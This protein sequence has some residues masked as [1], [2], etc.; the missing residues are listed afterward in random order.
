MADSLDIVRSVAELR[1]RVQYWRDQ[2]LKVALVPT[3]GA[4]HAGHLSLI[5][6][7]LEA[8]DRV[9]AS[10]FVNP[11]QFGPNEDFSRYPRQEERDARLLEGGGCHLLFAPSV[12]EMYPDGFATTVS[13]TGVS[14]GLCGGARPGHFN[15]VATVVTKLLLQAQAHV[16]LFGEKDW[17]QLTVIRRLVADLDIP[18]EVVGVPTVREADGLALSS[19]N[20]YLSAADRAIAPALHRALQAVADGLRQGRGPQE[21][22][23]RAAADL[24]AAGF[25]SV[26]Y[27]EARTADTLE[28]LTRLDRPARILAAARLGGARLIDNIG[29][30][31]A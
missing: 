21:L 23:H 11:T 8:A 3:M 13:V 15:G 26:D 6:A 29:V 14:E 25:L 28:I 12:S 22:C 4:L 19:R 31:P 10:V 2:G 27:V 7:A 17:Q 16:A 1:N 9:V 18:V 30:D 24:L 20:A 5:H